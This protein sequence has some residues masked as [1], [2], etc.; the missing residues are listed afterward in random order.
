MAR[1]AAAGGLLTT[2]KD[3]SKFLISLFAGTD[4]DP[5]RLNAASLSEMFRPQVKLPS[6]QLIDECTSWGLG[7]GIQERRTGNL[8][9]HSGGQ[10]GFR[11]LTMASLEKK[12]GFVA[13]TNGD[14]GGKMVY[15]LQ[16]ALSYLWDS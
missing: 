6:D 5:F 14:N 15:H 11:S 16:E 7:W 12:S 13:L 10:A 4:T 8:I 1:Y 9:V 3:Y 2:A